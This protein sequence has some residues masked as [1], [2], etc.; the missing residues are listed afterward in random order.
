[1]AGGSRKRELH[2]E[3][4]W[5]MV[6]GENDS[7]DTS[8]IHDHDNIVPSS[9]S[10]PSQFSGSQPFS[11][12][13]QPYSISGSQD[14]NQLQNFLDKAETDDQVIL[15]SP[16]RPSVPSSIRQSSRENMRHRSPEPEFFMPKV[17]IESPRRDSGSSSMTQR[18]PPQLPGLRRRQQG[19]TRSDRYHE[20]I[21]GPRD[22]RSA[23]GDRLAESLRNGV[24]DT[25]GWALS[26]VGLAFGYAKKPL[27]LL[28]AIYFIFGGLIIA[29]NMVTKSVYVSLSPL[30]RIPG[31]SYLDLPFCPDIIPSSN[32]DK[33]SDGRPVEF[34][35]LVKVQNQFE[36]VLEKSAEGVSLP[37]EMKRTEASV[38]DLRTMVRYSQLQ[39]KDELVLEFDEFIET[40]RTASSDLQTFNT[41]VGSAVDAV[42]S[43][44][45][46][47]S[48]YLDTIEHEKESRGLISDWTS[49]VFSP[50]QPAVF[51]ERILLDKYVEH[52]SLV[53]DKILAL[54]DEAQAVL[55]MLTKADGH[56]GIIHDF[57]T[58][59]QKTV[60]GQKDEI[61]WTLWTVV[62]GNSRHLSN[63]NA[64]LSTLQLVSAQRTTAVNQVTELI[65]EL[66]KIQ[67]GLDSL[68]ERVREPELV[69]DKVYVPLSVHIE[70]IDRGVERLDQAR[71][72]MREFEN[73][74]IKEVLARGQG[75]GGER[76]I[77]A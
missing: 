50:F 71:S 25:L 59:T 5:R 4:S 54:V 56:L 35:G 32:N 27:A 26:V 52:T 48:R 19:G 44:N 41:H 55:R 64:Q 61:L 66:Q 31:A 9:A 24:F 28:L 12:G 13:S 21:D 68:R 46:W 73:E 11:F 76:L 70:T 58:R 22:T 3:S 77:E 49:W 47:T 65:V 16:F 29:Q 53:S 23:L 2:V 51:S 60:Q 39:G 40:A 6:E 45:R 72:R 18:P 8:I 20:T 34:E 75:R 67:A 10:D 38:R 63:L 43:I 37:M 15:K 42:I 74:R 30:C 7:F 57:V 17:A 1:M 36:N 62:G 33:T 14:D 69:R